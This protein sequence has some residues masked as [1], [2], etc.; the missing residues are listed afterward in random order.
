[1]VLHLP[2]GVIVWAIGL[3]DEVGLCDF[4][5]SRQL[6]GKSLPGVLRRQPI[7]FH[8]ALD[9]GRGGASGDD[10]LVIGCRLCRLE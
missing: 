10:H 9:L 7:A 5:L 3:D 1:M 2:V 4:V 6:R 8:E